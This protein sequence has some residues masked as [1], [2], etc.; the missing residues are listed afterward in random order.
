LIDRAT[1][2]KLSNESTPRRAFQIGNLAF[3]EQ[4]GGAR[5]GLILG[6][7]R[8]GCGYDIF[9]FLDFEFLRR[10]C[11]GKRFSSGR[12]GAKGIRCGCRVGG[13]NLLGLLRAELGFDTRTNLE[14]FGCSGSE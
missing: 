7:C 1:G 11:L 12:G 9:D 10:C 8:F 14:T 13:E 6:G 3:F 5:D 2:L 4:E